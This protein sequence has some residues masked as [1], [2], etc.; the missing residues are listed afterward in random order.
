MGDKRHAP[1]PFNPEK[2]TPTHFPGHLVDLSVGLHGSGNS[3]LQT[4]AIPTH[5]MSSALPIASGA[6]LGAEALAPCQ[7]PLFPMKRL[8]DSLIIP[9]IGGMNIKVR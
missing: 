4:V 2:D 9:P 1:S 7:S 6:N 5:R 3:C 8:S